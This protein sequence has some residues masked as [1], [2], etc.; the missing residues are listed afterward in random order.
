KEEVSTTNFLKSNEPPKEEKDIHRDKEPAGLAL[1]AFHAEG[2]PGIL[3]V[4]S[5]GFA[6]SVTYSI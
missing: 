1:R 6:Y 2:T 3:F 5:E 4:V